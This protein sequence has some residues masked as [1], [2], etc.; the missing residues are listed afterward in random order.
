MRVVR[1]T[2]QKGP[3][4]HYLIV[5]SW[6]SP[7]VPSQWAFASTT[8]TCQ[9]NI[10]VRTKVALRFLKYKKGETELYKLPV[11][12]TCGMVFLL[13]LVSSNWREPT[14]WCIRAPFNHI[15]WWNIYISVSSVSV[16]IIAMALKTITTDAI[17]LL[18]FV[19]EIQQQVSA[20]MAL[21]V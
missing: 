21:C 10:G 17:R 12:V 9:T 2:M 14:V 11:L 8:I 13:T 1:I 19:D 15:L 5:C 7:R 3:L 16:N 20:L 4:S 6:R 18:I